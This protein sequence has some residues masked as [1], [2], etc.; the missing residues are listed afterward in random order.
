[1]LWDCTRK[2]P[3]LKLDRLIVHS[4]TKDTAVVRHFES[5]DNNITSFSVM[6]RSTKLAH[7]CIH[8]SRKEKNTDH[9]EEFLLCVLERKLTCSCT[10]RTLNKITPAQ[11]CFL[12]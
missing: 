10:H 9:I 11:K 5:S 1:V 2:G 3:H 7:R 12:R 8:R 6:S 4:S